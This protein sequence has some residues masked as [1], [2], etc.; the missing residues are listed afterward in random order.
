MFALLVGVVGVVLVIDDQHR[1]SPVGIEIPGRQSE[2]VAVAA[3]VVDLLQ[4]VQVVE[5]PAFVPFHRIVL[6]DDVVIVVVDVQFLLV[7]TVL[8]VGEGHREIDYAHHRG[9]DL[10]VVPRHLRIRK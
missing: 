2:T 3:V 5:I 1:Q 10:H 4:D 8:E 9:V 6:A 7:I